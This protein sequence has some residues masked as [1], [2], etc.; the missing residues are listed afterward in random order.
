MNQIPKKLKKFIDEGKESY[1]N[2]ARQNPLLQHFD[3]KRTL[4]S[5]PVCMKCE[6]ICVHERRPDDP[7]SRMIVDKDSGILVK[8][9]PYVTCYYCGYHGPGGP[10]FY[11]H[12]REA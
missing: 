4:V 1:F 9:K 6:R 11:I 2:H 3:L 7:P 12:V 10:P 5:M 8:S